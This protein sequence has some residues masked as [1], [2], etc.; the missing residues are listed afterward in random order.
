MVMRRGKPKSRRCRPASGYQHRSTGLL[1]VTELVGILEAGGIR[2]NAA[3]RATEWR[4]WAQS[5]GFA[6]DR[7]QIFPPCAKPFV[8]CRSG[9]LSSDCLCPLLALSGHA[10]RVV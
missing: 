3:G 6:G 10:V 5:R 8:T 2:L 7:I 9:E 1:T 4:N